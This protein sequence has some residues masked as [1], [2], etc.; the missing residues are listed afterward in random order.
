MGGSGF[1]FPFSQLSDG[2]RR[3]IRAITGLVFDQR[4]LM[5][6]EQPENSIHP[7]LLRKL[8]DVF[9]SYSTSSQVIFTT[10]S[11]DVLDVLGPN[12]VVFISAPEGAT[13]A[14]R[15]SPAEVRRAKKYLK[16]S[17]SLSEYIELSS[18]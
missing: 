7:G 3:V 6:L 18:D 15:L 5:L 11:P 10:H 1:L 13:K 17:G 9:R 8:I 16:E 4:S 12:E 2:T 14:R